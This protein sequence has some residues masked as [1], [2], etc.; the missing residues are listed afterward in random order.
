MVAAS[1]TGALPEN[2][3]GWRA[4][5]DAITFR[6]P[7]P[8]IL[9]DLIFSDASVTL[10]LFKLLTIIYQLGIHSPP[11][12]FWFGTLRLQPFTRA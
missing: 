5:K 12:T 9:I 4:G 3:V 2:H 8:L 11:T 7:A 6:D 10:G 1:G